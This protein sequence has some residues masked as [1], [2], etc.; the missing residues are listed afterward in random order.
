MRAVSRLSNREN[1][2]QGPDE[3]RLLFLGRGEVT[4]MV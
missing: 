4:T 1:D 2:G 3:Y